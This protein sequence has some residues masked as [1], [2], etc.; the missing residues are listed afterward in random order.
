[1]ASAMVFTFDVC[2]V[3]VIS[4]S[5]DTRPTQLNFATSKRSPGVPR[6]SS[7]IRPWLRIPI[8]V[9]S[10]G[11]RLNRWLAAA[12][13]PAAGMFCATTDGWPG[14]CRADVTRHHAAVE[15]DPAARVRPDDQ[16][17]G[18][19]F[20]RFVVG[21]RPSGRRDAS[22]AAASPLRSRRKPVAC[23]CSSGRIPR[24][25]FLLPKDCA[26]RSCFART[27]L[28]RAQKTT[29]SFLRVAFRCSNA[30]SV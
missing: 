24:S 25:V 27:P 30:P 3:K 11:A 23:A 14:R 17:D 8:A 7:R 18:A 6:I 12:M 9:P 19:A 16:R 5:D 28:P 4:T 15:I 20:E 22:D 13:L 2:Q 21:L 26:S 29:R 1:M 10:F